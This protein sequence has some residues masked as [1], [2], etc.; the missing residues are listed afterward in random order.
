MNQWRKLGV[1]I[2]Y[3]VQDHLLVC[4]IVEVSMH[5]PKPSGGVNI[6]RCKAVDCPD[7]D[8]FPENLDQLQ[9]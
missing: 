2:E 5:L 6:E 4:G 8:R 1:L 9:N 3:H 7:T